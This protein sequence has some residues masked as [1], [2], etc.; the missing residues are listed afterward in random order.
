MRLAGSPRAGE[1]ASAAS[2][3]S[4]RPRR[5]KAAALRMVE[6]LVTVAQTTHRRIALNAPI[7]M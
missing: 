2:A 4:R 1:D 3:R 6:N 5:P 7:F